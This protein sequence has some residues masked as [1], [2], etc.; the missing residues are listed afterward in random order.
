MSGLARS[1]WVGS[2]LRRPEGPDKVAGRALYTADLDVPGA[3]W[4]GTV[5]S[6]VPRG[7][8]LGFDFDPAFDFERVVLAGPEDIP[9]DNVVQMIVDDQPLLASDAVEHVGQ[10]LLL[11]AAEDPATLKQALAAI[12]PRIEPLE[13]VLDM[14][15]STKVLKEV[16]VD[17]GDVEAAFADAA[18][19]FEGVYR[20]DT[21]EQMYI[22]PQAFVGFPADEDDVVTVQGSLQCPYYV[23]KSLARALGLAPE[24]ARV[25][26][27]ET[28]GGFGGKED[29][30]S[31]IGCHAALLARR[32]G[33]PVWMLYDRH[34]DLVV[35]PKRHPSRVRHRTAVDGDGRLLALDVDVLL[36]GGAFTTL[37]PVVLSRGA[38]HAAG[39]YRCPNVRI[40]GR[41]VATNRVPFGAFRGFGAPQTCFAVERQ[42]DRIAAGLGIH[43][44]ELRRRNMLVLGD[45]TATGQILKTSVGSE[46]V[47]ADVL[48]RSGFAEH[49]WRGPKQGRK[50]RGLGLSFFFHGAGFTGSGEELL[51]G[52]VEVHLLDD[53][54]ACIA[55]ASTEI[56][57][58]TVAMFTAIAAD[59]LGCDA[60]D[61]AI[62]APD[63]G[64]VPDSGPTVASRTCM[65]VGGCLD[66]ACRELAERLGGIGD[67]ARP[68]RER[69]RAFVAGGGDRRV[70]VTYS[71]PPGLEWDEERYRG[72][73]YPVYGWAADVAEV[74][75]DLDTFDVEVT[76]FWTAVDCGRAIQPQLVEGQVEGGTLQAIG[77]AHLEVV[78]DLDGRTLQ[79]TMATCIIPT[80]MDTPPIEVSLIEEPYPYGPFGAKGV[81]EL[82]MDGG[83]CAVVSAIEDALGIHVDRIPATAERLMEAWLAAH[84]EERL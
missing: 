19:V 76:R 82:P 52:R 43:P 78:S 11:V 83:A 69:A 16:A 17:K 23:Q 71:S 24:K 5:R 39:A 75:V 74:E 35:T 57:Q 62:E 12:R 10:A 18:H 68:F 29:Y 54:R 72:D 58:G 28:G 36:D 33:R 77:F 84:P 34:E 45:T 6:D 25:V 38:I 73:A 37:S 51:A 50:R 15:A 66:K 79:D 27:R 47:F 1:G 63:T 49:P 80:T 26:Q 21:Q 44:A 41:V 22:E 64:R 65:I 40:R 67:I 13:P 30:P 46:K 4:G 3:W 20:T 2:R 9:G 61:V 53:G 59:A 32:T 8:L 42:M 81:G 7:R 60:E 48:A 55:A 70:S 14:E 31:I 56:G